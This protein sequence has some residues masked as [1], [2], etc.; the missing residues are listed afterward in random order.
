MPSLV[1]YGR[2]LQFADETTLIYVGDNCAEVQWKLEHDLQLLL[3]WIDSSRMK[4]N[5]TK[6]SIMWFKPKHGPGTSHSPVIIDGQPLQEVEEQKY[7]G[8]LF[9]SKFQWGPQVNYVCKKASYYLYLFCSH[10]KSLTTDILK[11]LTESLI[12]S[13]FDYALPVWGSPLQKCQVAHLQHLQNRAI[14]VTKSLRKYDHV[15]THRNNLNW[16]L[17]SHQIKFRSICAVLCYYHQNTGCLLLDPPIQFGRQHSYQ[18]RCRENFASVALCHLASTKRHFCSA[19]STWWNSLPAHIYDN[20]MNF[21]K[22]VRKFYLNDCLLLVFLLLY[23]IIVLYVVCMYVCTVFYYFVYVCIVLLYY[24]C[25]P[26]GKN[27]LCRLLEGK[28]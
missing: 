8:I 10:R 6:S 11:M 25:A 22:E 28:L 1:K 3:D 14:R 4:L 7:L 27:G 24:L 5:I 12:L 9:D 16:L 15:S 26:V 18:T 19:A 2:L 17:I 21:M 20:N 13:R 23:I